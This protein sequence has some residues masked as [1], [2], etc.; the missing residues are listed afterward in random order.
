MIG[1]DINAPPVLFSENWIA[2]PVYRTWVVDDEP[3]YTGSKYTGLKSGDNPLIDIVAYQI[4]DGYVV[5]FNLPNP[6]AWQTTHKVLPDKIYDSQIA[7]IGEY[8]YLFGG[9]ITDKI[10]KAN[11]NTPLDWVDTGATLP[12]PLF[13]SQLALIDNY[14]YL[15]GGGDDDGYSTDVIYRANIN[16][17]LVWEDTGY[18]LPDTLDY[19]QLAII[20]N[21]IYLYGGQHEIDARDVIYRA[22]VAT[23]WLWEDT[24]IHLPQP[25]FGHQLCIWDGYVYLVGGLDF[26]KEQLATV[27]KASLNDPT[28]F[29]LSNAL[30]LPTAFG[31]LTIIGN[32]AYYLG[33][34]GTGGSVFSA[35][36]DDGYYPPLTFR[37]EGQLIPGTATH[38]QLGIINDRL[39]LFGGNGSTIIW[40]AANTLKYELT[41]KQVLDYGNITRTEYDSISS[42]LDLFA[43]LGFPPWKTDYGSY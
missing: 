3:D 22:S 19:S 14:I 4:P 20:N 34:Y 9:T 35:P 13:G 28:N 2:A 23:P 5:D 30:P 10:W 6:K 43:L 18:K 27:Y 8:A 36:L 15:F 39:F 24:G 37:D 1:R 12:G 26:D 29:Y 33:G 42:S 21:N 11:L 7:I 31:Q 38:S 32:K 16:D 40:A 25:M 41:K 17:P